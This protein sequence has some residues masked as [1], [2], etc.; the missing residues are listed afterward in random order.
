[1]AVMTTM[2]AAMMAANRDEYRETAAE[3]NRDE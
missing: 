3:R 2:V 1:V